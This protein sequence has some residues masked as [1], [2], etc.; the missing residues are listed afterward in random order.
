MYKTRFLLLV[1]SLLLITAGTLGCSNLRDADDTLFQTST[2]DA[3]SKGIFDG[4]ITFDE[5]K[6]YGDFGLGTFDGLDGEMIA[7]GNEFFQIKAD[8]N[9]YIVADSQETPFSVVT[10]FAPDKVVTLG[11][12]LDMGQFTQYLD[13]LLPSKNIFYAVRVQG[14]FAYVKARSIGRQ[15]EPY[16]TLADALKGQK[17][18][19]FHNVAGAMVGI[20][21][22]T[23]AEG[24]NVPGYHFHF[25]TAD[26]KAGGHVLE[27]RVSDGVEVG[28]DYTQDF[29]MVSPDT[30]EFYKIDLTKEEQNG[31]GKA[32]SAFE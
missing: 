6:Q 20:R 4:D 5:L 14:T 29:Y 21:C 10:R 1:S 23:Y 11:Q 13:T 25:I 31:A 12:A 32:G 8:G 24:L 15:V 3:L 16:P 2:I 28:I 30:V 17:I 18:F 9:A 7:V 19:E 26:R 22:P 27:C